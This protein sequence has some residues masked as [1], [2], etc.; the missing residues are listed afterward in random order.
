MKCAT[1][2][3]VSTV[4]QNA[5]LAREELEQA[6]K[7]RGFEITLPIEET[8]SGA[9]NSRPGLQ[10]VMAA[11]RKGKIDAVLV[12]KLDR[13][14]RSCMDLLHNIEAL[15]DCGVR[16]IAITQGL[17]IKPEGD[18]MSN[19][20]LTILAAVAQFERDLIIERT[21]LGLA[22]AKKNGQRLGRPM[23]PTPVGAVTALQ[24]SGFSLAEI[25]EE[26]GCTIKVV[27]NRLAMAKGDGE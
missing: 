8:G 1:Y 23:D 22:A 6:A 4:D 5:S 20:I 21:R 17:D 2:H 3:R 26:L 11:A 19:L 25:A 12:Y 7:I 15:R 10:K 16:F 13:F 24:E 14:G 9:R 27:R 18:A